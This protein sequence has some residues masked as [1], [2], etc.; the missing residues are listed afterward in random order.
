MSERDKIESL[1]QLLERTLPAVERAW[2][3]TPG[4]PKKRDALYL[5]QD[6]R[7]ALAAPKEP[8]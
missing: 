3:M 1:R 4:G 5:L 7:E 6:V 2:S 8:P